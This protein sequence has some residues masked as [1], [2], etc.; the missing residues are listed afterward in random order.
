MIKSW[1][2][3]WFS[4]SKSSLSPNE[5]R[6]LK[7]QNQYNVAFYENYF[8]LIAMGAR[9]KLVEAMFNLDLFSLFE[10]QQCVAE[11][12]IIEKLGL[13]P[14]RAKKWLH[15]LSAEHY[16]EQ[17]TTNDGQV[18]YQLPEEFSQLLQGEGKRWMT[19]FFASWREVADEN[20]T[21]TLLFGI[22]RKHVSWPPKTEAEVKLL[23]DWMAQTAEQPLRCLL[24]HIKFN[25]VNK[26]LD[27]GGGDGTMACAFVRAHPHLHATVYNQPLPAKL[28]RKN[29]KAMKLSHQVT[30]LEGNFIEEDALP[31]G[32][33][34]IVF[35][36]V[37]FDWD[38]TICRKL[39]RMAYQALPKNGL[40]AICEFFK[41]EL[42]PGCLIA[43]YRYIFFDA[44][45]AHIMKAAEEYRSMLEEIGFTII[46]PNTEKKQPF[47][48]CTLILAQK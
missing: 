31:V 20:L 4:K 22:T 30:V 9:L 40:L 27:V 33:D 14:V 5:T 46:V 48:D 7:E 1:I 42:D 37:L 24:D 8:S 43:E 6:P 15:L 47:Y 28:A 25:E 11:R 39:L 23:E 44:F 38:E 13:K 41:D 3:K 17:I 36:R 34:L 26:L 10:N 35:T 12:D 16:L 19:L 29:I 45:A 18:A 21:E 2:K 32:F